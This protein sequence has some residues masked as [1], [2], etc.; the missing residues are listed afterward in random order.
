MLTPVE[1]RKPRLL[2]D[3]LR[4]AVDVSAMLPK[5]AVPVVLKLSEAG[6][7]AFQLS[8]VIFDSGNKILNGYPAGAQILRQ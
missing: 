4:D 3:Q 1:V 7:G 8:N 5:E 6:I 2:V